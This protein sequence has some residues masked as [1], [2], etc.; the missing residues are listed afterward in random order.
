MSDPFKSRV[1]PDHNASHRVPLGTG[2]QQPATRGQE[3]KRQQEEQELR[4]SGAQRGP[5]NKRLGG[6]E[7]KTALE[8]KSS[9]DQ[10]AR[11]QEVRRPRAGEQE[12]RRSRAQRGPENKRLGG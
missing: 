2:N 11:V 10:E 3:N 7:V 8:N 5:E 9:R 12:L 6:Q 4:R 1:P